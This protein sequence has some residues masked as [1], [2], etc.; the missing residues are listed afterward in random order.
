MNTPNDEPRPLERRVGR[1]T[2]KEWLL[3]LALALTF[4]SWVLKIQRN[5][6]NTSIA[7]LFLMPIK[8]VRLVIS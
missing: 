6:R 1:R 3:L 8:H 2:G 7:T 4:R 5:T